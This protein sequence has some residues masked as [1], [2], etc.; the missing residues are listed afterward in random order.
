MIS[1][2]EQ[3]YLNGANSFSVMNLSHSIKTEISIKINSSYANQKFK[4]PHEFM[5]MD[6]VKFVF[7][8]YLNSNLQ[9][10]YSFH[11]IIGGI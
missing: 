2:Q 8:K 5:N 11:K 10:K 9:T 7:G 3:K 4:S 6:I 1:N